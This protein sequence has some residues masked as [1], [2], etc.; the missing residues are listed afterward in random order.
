MPPIFIS[1]SIVS[2]VVPAISETIALSSFNRAF[3]KVDLPTFGLPEITTG[4]PFLMALPKSNDLINL[5]RTLCMLLIS[6]FNCGR[7]ANSTSSSEKSSSNS[8]NAAKSINCWRKA[9]SSLEKPPLSWRKAILW[10]A[11]VLLAIKSATASACERSN[12]P[13]RKARKVNSPGL[14]VLAPFFINR[15][16]SFWIIYG[17]A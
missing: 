5:R 8:I 15:L 10:E 14:A 7:L 17:E 1:S 9:L 11:S 16:I 2:R 13:L 4:I 3:N 6:A 12:C